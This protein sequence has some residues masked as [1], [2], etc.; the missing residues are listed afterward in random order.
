MVKSY[1]RR[2]FGFIMCQATANSGFSAVGQRQA[3]GLLKGRNGYFFTEV[4]GIAVEGCVQKNTE[5]GY[6][7]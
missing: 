4:S 1:N 7:T 6:G 3:P 2:G 5:E